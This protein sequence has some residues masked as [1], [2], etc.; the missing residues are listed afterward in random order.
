VKSSLLELGAPESKC[1]VIYSEAPI[2]ISSKDGANDS[3]TEK[4][5]RFTVL[6]VGQLTRDKGVDI[7]IRAAMRMCREHADIEYLVAGDYEWKNAFAL[8][9][10]EDVQRAGLENRIRFLGYVDSVRDLHEIS[11][12]HVLPSV[13]EDPLPNVVMEAK[14]AGIPSV[15]FPSGGVPE[16]VEHECEGYVCR[17]RTEEG[18]IAGIEYYIGCPERTSAHG[19]NALA[20][21]ERLGTACYGERWERVY[22]ET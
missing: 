21:L 3:P 9:L 18:L 12:L 13:W 5:S 2:R 6:Y 8:A 20:S 10:K 17:D 1:N 11:D 22:A 19:R 4:G 7:L 15:V 16:V 14:S